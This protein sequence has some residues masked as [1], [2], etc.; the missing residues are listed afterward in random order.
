MEPDPSLRDPARARKGKQWA[1][2][3][4]NMQESKEADI[5]THK[6]VTYTGI[7]WPLV[8]PVPSKHTSTT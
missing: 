2:T 6:E 1:T 8:V 5:R 3:S 7:I 4:Q